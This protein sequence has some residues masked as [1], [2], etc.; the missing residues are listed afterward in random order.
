M[1][2]CAW[3]HGERM[4]TAKNRSWNMV[5]VN[6]SEVGSTKEPILGVTSVFLL[7]HSSNRGWSS[8]YCHEK[9]V[10]SDTNIV[11]ENQL[12]LIRSG[13]VL[14]CKWV[15]EASFS[16]SCEREDT[17][18]EKCIE[19]TLP[20]WYLSLAYPLTKRTANQLELTSPTLTASAGQMVM[21]H[22]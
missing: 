20:L 17:V 11:N 18:T 12:K 10:H 9:H 5:E 22:H 7:I 21:S 2:L 19:L 6:N 1:E 8:P 16:Q 4:E 3:W 14:K 15:E 13:Q